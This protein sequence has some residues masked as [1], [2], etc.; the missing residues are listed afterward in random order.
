MHFVFPS[1]LTPSISLLPPS[2]STLLHL[3]PIATINMSILTVHERSTSDSFISSPV[4]PKST[5]FIT[6]KANDASASIEL[7]AHPVARHTTPASD[8]EDQVNYALIYEGA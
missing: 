6:N 5:T 7:L 8:P 3:R 1:L 4:E 2:P